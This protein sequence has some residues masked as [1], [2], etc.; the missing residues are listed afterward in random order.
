MFYVWG[1]S[2]FTTGLDWIYFC[3]FSTNIEGSSSRKTSPNDID[4]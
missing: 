2:S 4:W 3:L 1:F